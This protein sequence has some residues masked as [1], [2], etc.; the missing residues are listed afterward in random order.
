MPDASAAPVAGSKKRQTP[1]EEFESGPFLKKVR[2]VL[3]YDLVRGWLGPLHVRRILVADG[4]DALA[5]A[6]TVGE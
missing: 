1:K 3:F 6:H 4:S 5:V 2:P